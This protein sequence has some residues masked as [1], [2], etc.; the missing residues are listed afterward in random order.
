[1]TKREH[2]TMRREDGAQRLF[3]VTVA[4]LGLLALTPALPVI[5]T[6]IVVDDGLPV[7]FRQVR[8]GRGRAPF[9][10][11]KLRSMRDG[12]VTR[13]G[14]WLRSTGLDEVTQLWNVMRGEM[15]IVGPRPLTPDD[16]A[17]LRWDAPSFDLRFGARPGLTG[18]VQVLGPISAEDSARLEREY[19]ARRSVGVDLAIVGATSAMLVLGKRRVRGWLR[20]A[21]SRPHGAAP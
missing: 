5:A 15:S 9:S 21:L 8:L 17:R 13:V 4:G 2:G 7:L 12:R 11:L 18:P 1:M 14:A 10:L 20:S 3:D 6:L 16:V 19:L